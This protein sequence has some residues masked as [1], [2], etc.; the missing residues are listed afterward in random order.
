MT[1]QKRRK[2]VV[3]A[4]Y[5]LLEWKSVAC[6]KRGETG[7]EPRVQTQKRDNLYR[8]RRRGYTYEYSRLVEQAI[9]GF[10][11]GAATTMVGYLTYYGN[12]LSLDIPRIPWIPNGGQD[13]E[14][15]PM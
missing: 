2:M 4:M 7:N 10:A 3:E 15:T 13:K 11:Q 12:H 14:Q 6:V 9:S 5:T 1:R 8:R